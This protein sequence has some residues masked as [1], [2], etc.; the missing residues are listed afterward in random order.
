LKAEAQK[1]IRDGELDKAKEILA[2]V[3]K[4]QDEAL[5]RLALNAAQTAAQLGDVAL[6]QLRYPEAAG[7]FS[8]AAAKVPQGH[9]DERWKYLNA[10]SA[11]LYRQG[12]EFGDNAAAA[13]AIERYHHLAELRPQ[14][15]FSREW[16]GTQM[17]L[18]AGERDGQARGGGFRL[19]RSLAGKNPRA[20]AAR[21]GHDPDES[22]QCPRKVRRA[23]ERDGAAR[24]GRRRLSRSLAGIY[25]PARAAPMGR[26]PD[27]SRQCA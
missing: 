3:E 20:R 25:P 22:R 9:D 21:M 24:R 7:D 13:S 17:N 6:T 14:N 8:R 2:K 10:E 1:A 19:S 18:E 5:D 15:A 11:S 26:D 16:A 4:I 23:G 12:D 27:E